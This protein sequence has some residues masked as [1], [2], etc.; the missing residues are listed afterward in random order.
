MKI[1][2]PISPSV[3]QKVNDVG[4]DGMAV[5]AKDDRPTWQHHMK[6]YQI[7]SSLYCF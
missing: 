3:V 6:D 7:S 2:V 1:I 4:D 5:L